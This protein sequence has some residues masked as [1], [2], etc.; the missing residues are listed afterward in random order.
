MAC[1]AL[2]QQLSGSEFLLLELLDG[3]LKLIAAR[4]RPLLLTARITIT[5]RLGF[6]RRPETRV[7]G[8][9]VFMNR[10]HRF[11]WN[12]GSQRESASAEEPIGQIQISQVLCEQAD[13]AGCAVLACRLLL[14][15]FPQSRHDGL[16]VGLSLGRQ[17][18]RLLDNTG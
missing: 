2:V 13:V 17:R 8:G 18:V 10:S 3:E 11:M 16:L 1:A 15:Q 5:H 6:T 4:G 14:H 12:P 9:G 7:P